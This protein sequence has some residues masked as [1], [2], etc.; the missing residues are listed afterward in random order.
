MNAFHNKIF[1][2]WKQNRKEYPWRNTSDPYHIMVAEF[3][4]QQTQASRVSPKFL[5]FI[6]ALPTLAELANAPTSQV[7]KLW[8]GL[9]YNRRAIYL[10]QAAEQI[11]KLGS[12]PEEPAELIKIKGIGAYTSRSIPIFAFNKDI[13]T[14]DTNIRKVFIL[15]GYAQENTTQ[16]ELFALADRLVPKGK[17]RDWHNALMDYGNSL[18]ALPTKTRKSP[19]FKGSNRYYRGKI[20][21]LVT[22]EPKSEKELASALQLPITKLLK[23]LTALQMEGFILKTGQVWHLPDS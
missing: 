18:P 5:Q 22:Q 23:I 1:N 10:K 8:S 6:D 16:K 19:K 9:G 13:G 20:L 21:K 15:E 14:V 4:L 2:W 11:A 3:M 7:L 12:F 17:S